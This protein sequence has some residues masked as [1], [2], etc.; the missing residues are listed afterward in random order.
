MNKRQFYSHLS[1]L[2]AKDG[3]MVLP[4]PS[5]VSALFGKR[6]GTLILTLG[7]YESQRHEGRVTADFALA[8]HTFLT[9]GFADAPRARRRVGSFLVNDERTQLLDAEYAMPGVSDAWWQGRTERTASAIATAVRLTEARFL[10]QPG[11]VG[12][13]EASTRHAEY[14]AKLERVVGTPYTEPGAGSVAPPEEWVDAAITV[15]SSSDSEIRRDFAEKVAADAWR[16][17]RLLAQE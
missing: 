1:G 4:G 14:L 17:S 6:V 9:M 10:A 5:G 8:R 11:L 7:L 3:W 12:E 2:L 15:F 16:T 13:V